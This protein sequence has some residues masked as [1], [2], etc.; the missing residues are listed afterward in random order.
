MPTLY[1]KK[2]TEI[3]LSGKSVCPVPDGCNR[4]SAPYA[5]GMRDAKLPDPALP[6][7]SEWRSPGHHGAATPPPAGFPSCVHTATPKWRA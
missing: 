6:A 4:A 1:P 2:K 7:R 5:A 3:L